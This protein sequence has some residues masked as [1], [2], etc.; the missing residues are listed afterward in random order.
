MRGSGSNI[1]YRQMTQRLVNGYGLVVDRKTVRELSKILH[2]EG[3][4]LRAKRSLKRRQHRTRGSIFI[5]HM[6]GYDKLKPFGFCIHGAIDGFN[7]RILWLDVGPT[8]NDPSVICQYFVDHV[9]QLGGTVQRFFRQNAQDDL[10]AMNSFMYGK[11]VTNQR[12]EAWWGILGKDCTRWWI[13]FFKDM[14]NDGLFC[15]DYT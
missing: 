8:N 9:R 10:A 1:G 3:V 5:W 7:R 2:P 13:D 6:D 14:R 12:I 4:E 15:D 11:S